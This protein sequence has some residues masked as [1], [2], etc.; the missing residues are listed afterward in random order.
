MRSGYSESRVGSNHF[1]PSD[2]CFHWPLR[3][4]CTRAI[5]MLCRA[6]IWAADQ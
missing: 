1:T 6:C 3:N 2:S 5:R 4:A